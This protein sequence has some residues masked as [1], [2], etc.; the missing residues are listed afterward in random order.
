M[1]IKC[2][3]LIK[4]IQN[5]GLED[6]DLVDLQIDDEEIGRIS[7]EKDREWLPFPQYRDAFCNGSEAYRCKEVVVD[8]SLSDGSIIEK[9]EQNVDTSTIESYCQYFM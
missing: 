3:D 5:L 6:F 8:F 7:V 4:L 1:M 2:R 9:I